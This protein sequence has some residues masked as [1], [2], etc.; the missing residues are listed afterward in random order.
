MK[1]KYSAKYL[2]HVVL[3]EMNKG[4]LF[5]KINQEQYDNAK[6]I[7]WP[8]EIKLLGT[9]TK[10][11]KNKKQG[12]LTGIIYLAPHVE[13]LIY[14]GKNICPAASP[15]CSMACLGRRSMRL[16][17]QRGF[18]S[19]AWKTLLWL[20][21]PDLFKK[22]LIGEITKLVKRAAKLNLIPSVRLNGSS[23]ICWEKKF[24]M[25]FKL[26]PDVIFY[27]YTKISKRVMA[28]LPD[29]Y[30]LTFSQHE[31]NKPMSRKLLNS[32]YN[33]AIVFSNLEEAVKEGYKNWPVYDGDITDFR[34][35]DKSGVIGLSVKAHVKDST[36]F[37]IKNETG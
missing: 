21:R 28:K 3:R 6:K 25:L 23:D 20:Y 35:Y 26:F 34:P 12:V 17:M 13:S 15:G 24:P 5:E 11:Q 9:S 33:V 31:S 7:K 2:R 16:Y 10:V 14:G 30:K 36:G 18:N 22:I 19:K 1:T 27:D 8:K 37:I 32:G 29:N 4:L